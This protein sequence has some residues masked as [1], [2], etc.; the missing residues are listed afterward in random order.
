MCHRDCTRKSQLLQQLREFRK[1]TAQPNLPTAAGPGSQKAQIPEDP[2]TSR[3]KRKSHVPPWA[4]KQST[5]A[6]CPGGSPRVLG[7]DALGP[8]TARE[9]LVPPLGQL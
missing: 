7:D 4:E 6:T 8:G 3:T 2:A 9:T 1:G 5:Q